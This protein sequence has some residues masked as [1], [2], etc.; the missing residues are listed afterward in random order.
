MKVVLA[1]IIGIPLIAV[2][3]LWNLYSG[4]VGAD[5]RVKESYAQIQNVLER[6]AELIPNLVEVTKGYANHENSTLVAVAEAR[7]KVSKEGGGIAG[8]DPAKIASDPALQKQLADAGNMLRQQA[9][10]LLANITVERYPNLKA[11]G[12]FTRLSAELAGSINRVTQAR[13][14]NQQAVRDYN[15]K[16][17]QPPSSF[18]AG[19]YPSDF[20]VRPYY[21][22]PVESQKAPTV[23]FGPGKKE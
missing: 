5:E 8:V 13:R 21:E 3:I 19:Q 9:T 12:Q 16:V 11:I 14:V 22:A 1:V 20:P 10:A 6:Q 4:L 23:T 2:G 15:N 17:R 7:S 18:V